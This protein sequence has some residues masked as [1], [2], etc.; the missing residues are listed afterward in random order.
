MAMIFLNMAIAFLTIK[1]EWYW[2]IEQLYRSALL[3][4]KLI[5][6][7]DER[8]ITFINYLYGRFLFEQ[9]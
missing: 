4:A 9:S 8:T 7:D 2:L 3:N 1:C 5:Q 6:D